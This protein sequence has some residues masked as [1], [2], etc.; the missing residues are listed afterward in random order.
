MNDE[1]SIFLFLFFLFFLLF[2]MNPW[3]M[4]V[5]RLGVKLELQLLAYGTATEM[6]DPSHI[7]DLYQSSW[8]CQILNPPSEARGKTLNLMVSSWIHFCCA[9]METAPFYSFTWLSEY[10]PPSLSSPGQCQVFEGFLF[11]EVNTDTTI[12]G[13]L[14][15]WTIS[16]P[17]VSQ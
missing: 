16:Y 5:A 7:W 17:I 1:I 6:P 4:K 15:K 8:K 11:E 13:F 12:Y 2:R 14:I 3:H 10:R 9:M